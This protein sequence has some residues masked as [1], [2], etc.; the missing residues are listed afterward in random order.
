MTEGF[1]AVVRHEVSRSSHGHDLYLAVL[2][3]LDRAFV[4]LAFVRRSTTVV[5]CGIERWADEDTAAPLPT[6]VA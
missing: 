4:L 6:G 1:E 3:E 5:R 2:A